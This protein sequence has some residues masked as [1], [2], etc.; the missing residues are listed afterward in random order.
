MTA[1][2]RAIRDAAARIVRGL[3]SQRRRQVDST[4]ARVVVTPRPRQIVEVT[5]LSSL[6]SPCAPD[7][8]R[9]PLHAA[10]R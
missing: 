5:T 2:N 3:R 6:L 4:D 1:S 10:F 8:E 7:P 9:P